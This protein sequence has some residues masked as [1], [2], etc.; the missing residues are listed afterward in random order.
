MNASDVLGQAAHLLVAPETR[1]KAA[2]QFGSGPAIVAVE[3]EDIPFRLFATQVGTVNLEFRVTTPFGIFYKPVGYYWKD[4]RIVVLRE[5][6]ST[7]AGLVKSGMSEPGLP[8]RS[9]GS[10]LNTIIGACSFE[11]FGIVKKG[12]ERPFISNGA[13]LEMVVNHD[14]DPQIWSEHLKSVVVIY[15]RKPGSGAFSIDPLVHFADQY[16]Q[17]S[18]QEL[19]SVFKNA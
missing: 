9:L 13:S 12:L 8:I 15:R 1:S 19:M 6:E 4:G 11:T 10:D 17:L 18:N 3:N 7:L 5:F 2:R 14:G 16:S